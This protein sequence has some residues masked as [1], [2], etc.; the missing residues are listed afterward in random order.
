MRSACR[1]TVVRYAEPAEAGCRIR[2]LAHMPHGRIALLS[3]GGKVYFPDRPCHAYCDE[4]VWRGEEAC[5]IDCNPG[6]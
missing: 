5:A 6:G 3:D 4:R 1:H 2:D